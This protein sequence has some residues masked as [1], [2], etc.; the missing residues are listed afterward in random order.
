[1]IRKAFKLVLIILMIVTWNAKNDLDECV[2]AGLYFCRMETGGFVKVIKL[3][4]IK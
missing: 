4:L 1:M 3:A 2:V